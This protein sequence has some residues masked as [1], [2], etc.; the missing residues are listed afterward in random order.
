MIFTHR[1]SAL[2]HARISPSGWLTKASHVSFHAGKRLNVVNL[3]LILLPEY[4]TKHMDIA[5]VAQYLV[6][7]NV[8]MLLRTP[9]QNAHRGIGCSM[10]SAKVKALYFG[11]LS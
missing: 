2:H 1:H 4:Q 10:A 11:L 9:V 8:A 6:V 5:G 3:E 7:R